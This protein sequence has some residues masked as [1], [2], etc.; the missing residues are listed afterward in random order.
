MPIAPVSSSTSASKV[1]L[2]RESRICR[3]RT[4][5]IFV[6]SLLRADS[7]AAALF[8]QAKA[9]RKLG[10]SLVRGFELSGD[11]RRYALGGDDR[12]FRMAALNEIGRKIEPQ[13]RRSQALGEH[14]DG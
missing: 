5:T 6:I 13:C 11:L 12:A 2:P 1:G 3:A 9:E 14:I 8:G 7:A 4:A 10:R